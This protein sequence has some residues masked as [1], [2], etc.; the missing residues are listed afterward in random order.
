MFLGGKRHRRRHRRGRRG[1]SWKG[2][3]GK[4]KS[5]G[6]KAWDWGRSHKIASKIAREF[7]KDNVADGLEK[8][9]FGQR[10]RRRHRRGGARLPFNGGSNQ[11]QLLNAYLK[12]KVSRM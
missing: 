11:Q 6:K 1:G 10:R 12:T 8:M 4:I 3:W 5:V 7:G 2:V 9:G